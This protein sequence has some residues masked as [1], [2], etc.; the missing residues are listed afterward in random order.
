MENYFL[1]E[2]ERL[3]SA[4]GK[5]PSVLWFLPNEFANLPQIITSAYSFE[6]RKVDVFIV[7]FT[8]TQSSK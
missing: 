5:L 7:L 2:V 3:K 1:F 8:H 4:T 6:N